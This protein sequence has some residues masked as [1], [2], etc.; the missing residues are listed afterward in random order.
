MKTAISNALE[1]AKTIITNIWEGIKTA[2]SNA[3]NAVRN[4]VSNIFNAIKTLISNYVN[5][6]KTIIQIA[7]SVI[8]SIF[9]GDFGA[10]RDTV[11]NIFNSIKD[12]ISNA[13]NAAKDAVKTAIDKIKGFFNFT[14]S[15][16]KLKMPHFKASG[17]FSLNPPSVPKIS[18]DWYAKG[19]I[20]EKPT[21]FDFDP[22]TMQAKV[23]GEAGPEA[24]API[25]TLLGYIRTAVAEEQGRSEEL[26]MQMTALMAE[27][28]PQMANMQ[29]VTD[30]GALV[31]AI[32]PAMD[33][34]LGDIVKRR[35]RGN[36]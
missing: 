20:L 2:V 30:T 7:L 22:K 26:L 23:G 16:P 35:G 15:L 14:W 33:D 3:V 5:G 6:W 28:L 25:E 19:G 34:R 17:K 36:R 4:T 9:S 21:M 12:G 8:K 18:V 31:G 24:V 1:A 32:A 10:A 27:Y 13:I 11:L 29:M